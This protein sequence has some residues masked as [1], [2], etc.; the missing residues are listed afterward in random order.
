MKIIKN[1][2]IWKSL[3]SNKWLLFVAVVSFIYAITIT[4]WEFIDTPETHLKGFVNIFL[5][6]GILS[7]IAMGVIGIIASNR[8]TFLIIFPL[9]MVISGSVVY[10][11]HTL[12]T[13]ITGTSIEIA[14]E[15]NLDM[16]MSVIDISLILIV[17]FSLVFSGLVVAYRWKK[18]RF[19]GL[20]S[21]LGL[22]LCTL[23]ILSPLYITRIYGS[24]SNR[25]PYSMYI[26]MKDYLNNKSEVLQQRSAF[27]DVNVIKDKE[28]P[29][30]I[31]VIGESLRSDHLKFNGYERETMPLL[32]EE[33][34]LVNFS[35]MKS[36]GSHTFESIPYIMTRADSLSKERGYQEESFIT[37]FKKGGYTSAWIANQDISKSYSYFAHETDTL[38][39]VNSQR[40]LYTYDPWLDKDVIP[41]FGRWIENKNNERTLTII[42]SIGSHW[43][44]KSHYENEDAIFLPDIDSKELSVLSREQLINS[45]DNTIIATDKFIKDLIN[46]LTSRNALLIYLSDHGENLGENG[47]WLHGTDNPELH[48]I[49]CLIWYSD[50]YKEKFP[51]KVE[52]LKINSNRLTSS[53]DLF[54]SILD[55][56]ALTTPVLDISKSWFYEKKDRMD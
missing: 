2:N 51:E 31:L 24:V 5:Q 4:L 30:I 41:H 7:L 19:E 28:G 40:S 18:I 10:L 26:G 50:I 53:D 17:F 38:I 22:L 11:K 46:L 32:A 6:W 21:Y 8:V 55:G 16:W 52:S 3:R 47:N 44:Y 37:L 25:L 29:D 42:H 54:H 33:N 9:L 1:K 48:N 14:L 15:N 27:D 43:W 12:G 34:N 49:A 56:A 45:Y 39:H 36:T 35:G 13:G 23:L 20:W